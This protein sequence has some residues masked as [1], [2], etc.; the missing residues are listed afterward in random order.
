MSLSAG[1]LVIWPSALLRSRIVPFFGQVT[2]NNKFPYNWSFGSKTNICQETNRWFFFYQA[3]EEASRNSAPEVQWTSGV[4]DTEVQLLFLHIRVAL[5]KFTSRAHRKFF[6]VPEV[7][8]INM[9]LRPLNL[10]L[11]SACCSSV[12]TQLLLLVNKIKK[13]ILFQRRHRKIWN[14]L[15][16][17]SLII[18]SMSKGLNSH[19]YLVT[20]SL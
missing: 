19:T 11:R 8:N 13:F 14:H 20:L 18:F 3:L 16:S 9:A 5:R 4:P 10:H 7:H 17:I 2:W 15:T 1:V 12:F 6:Y